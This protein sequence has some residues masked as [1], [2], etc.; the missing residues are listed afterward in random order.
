MDEI[1]L[2]VGSNELGGGLDA[3]GGGFGGHFED[4][5]VGDSGDVSG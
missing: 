4:V 5:G 2:L 1:N 3:L